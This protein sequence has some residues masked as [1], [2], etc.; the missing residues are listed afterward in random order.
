MKFDLNKLNKASRRTV[1][2]ILHGFFTVLCEKPFSNVTIN[3]ICLVSSY[4]RATFYNYFDDKNDLLDYLWQTVLNEM[5]GDF[6]CNMTLK[7]MS[8][9]CFDRC[10]E[11]CHKNKE[12]MEAVV[13]NNKSD[14]YFLASLKLFISKNLKIMLDKTNFERIGIEIPYELEIEFIADCLFI[15]L[16]WAF[17]KN[18]PI[19]QDEAKNYLKI[20]VGSTII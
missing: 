1:N 9:F 18:K 16:E 15:I 20:M 12:K 11:Y 14:D 6:S 7:E 3:E 17:I 13:K 4:P 5:L 2:N 10:F 8:N 19:T